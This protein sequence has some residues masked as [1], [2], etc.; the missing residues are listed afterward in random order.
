MR[1]PGGFG[2]PCASFSRVDT[3]G[4]PFLAAFPRPRVSR[5]HE[6]REHL[7]GSDPKY[8]Q[9]M[10][11]LYE[12]FSKLIHYFVLLAREVNA[13]G[14]Y[15]VFEWPAHSRLWKEPPA[16]AMEKE[17]KMQRVRPDE[18]A[19]GLQARDGTRIMKPWAF[20]QH[21]GRIQVRDISLTRES[22]SRERT[23]RHT[24]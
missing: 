13:R 6:V 16:L 17:F 14:G 10:D 15:I 1:A 20:S 9:H 22:R 18:R 11:E 19:L 5:W 23:S 24:A 8:R 3:L 4:H 12:Q 2:L 7:R 21:S